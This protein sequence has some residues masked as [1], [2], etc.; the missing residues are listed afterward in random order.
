VACA[1]ALRDMNSAWYGLIFAPASTS[2]ITDAQHVAVAEFIEA[3]SPPAIYGVTTEDAGTPN[4]TSTTDL[5]Y[6]LK[7]QNL[8]RTFCQYS[9]SSLYAAVSA[10]ARG[11]TVDFTANNSTITLMF[12]NEPTIIAETLSQSQAAAI[13]AKNANVFVNYSNSTAILQYGT[14]TNGFFFDEVQG[15]DW[16]AANIQSRV[17]NRLLTLPKIPQT[18]AGTHEITNEIEAACEDGVN[19]GLIAPGIWNGPPVG[20]I[21]TGQYL[22][23][24]YFVYMPP[25]SSQ[26]EVVRATRAAPVAQTLVKLAGAIH[27]AD[28]IVNVNR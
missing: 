26:S 1:A 23:S 12:K 11:F 3:C 27:K 2:D 6:L 7:Q 15:T 17:F 22:P 16:L 10:F 13:A 14:M 21:Q 5:A 19:N 9:S 28:V 4:S 18:D 25:I 8:E 24:G 20:P